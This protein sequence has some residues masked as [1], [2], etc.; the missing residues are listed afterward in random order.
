MKILNRLFF[1]A[2]QLYT[3]RSIIL[4]GLLHHNDTLVQL[5]RF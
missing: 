5:V 2:V 3:N 1:I 4:S